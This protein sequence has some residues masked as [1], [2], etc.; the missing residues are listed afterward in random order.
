MANKPPPIPPGAIDLS[1][2]KDPNVAAV[3]QTLGKA[4]MSHTQHSFQSVFIVMM[5][6]KGIQLIDLNIQSQ[7]ADGYLAVLRRAEHA[8]LE[9]DKARAAAT[10]VPPKG[11]TKQ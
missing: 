2:L 6:D 7:H 3:R 11:V 8:I 9:G 10:P 1:Q 4:S 5:N